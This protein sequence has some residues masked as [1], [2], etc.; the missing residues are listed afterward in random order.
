VSRGKSIKDTVTELGDKMNPTSKFCT[1]SRVRG[2]DNNTGEVEVELEHG[3]N[4]CKMKRTHHL[5]M[6]S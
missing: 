4:K 3:G 1:S 5:A 6:Y 2:E